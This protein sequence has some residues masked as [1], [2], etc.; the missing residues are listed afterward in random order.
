MA[1]ASPNRGRR[2][3]CSTRCGTS[4]TNGR[5][6]EH[7]HD[8]G[9]VRGA[10]HARPRRGRGRLRPGDGEEPPARRAQP[11][12]PPARAGH[13][14]GRPG[15]PGAG[16]A[17]Q[18]RRRL[19]VV[20]RRGGCG[21]GLRAVRA[22]ARAA[23]RVDP[24]DRAEHRDVLDG[25][26]GRP[27]DARRPRRRRRAGRRVRTRLRD[28]GRHRPRRPAR[29]RRDLCALLQRGAARHRG[30]GA[31]RQGRG[32]ARL[33]QGDFA[34]G[35]KGTIVNPSGGVLCSNPIAVTGVARLAEATLQ[36][37][38]RAG[39]R[40]VEGARTAVASAI[41][42]DHQFYASL[43]LSADLEDIA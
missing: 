41:G 24:R 38:G 2:S 35:A 20:D 39:D 15:E 27:A 10:L 30:G 16:V 9:P 18:A 17:D 5:S 34:L 23:A 42:G 43:V 12:G 1:N 28:G 29:R 6:A 33:A 21:A 36:V 32:P 25:R 40:Q 26:P 22:G 19:P 37:Q 3:R 7:H 31:V 11:A 8:A 14:R 13:R 4:A